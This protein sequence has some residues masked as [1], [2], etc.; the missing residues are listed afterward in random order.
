MLSLLG[1]HST[2]QHGR[3][4]R[5]QP[6]KAAKQVRADQSATTHARKQ[7]RLEPA[8]R[9]GIRTARCVLETN[10]EI[11]MCPAYKRIY[12]HSRSSLADVM[13]PVHCSF[14][15]SFLFRLCLRRPFVFV[16]HGARGT[17]KSP[18]CIKNH[19]PLP[20]SLNRILFNSSLRASVAGAGSR[21]WSEAPC[22]YCSN[23]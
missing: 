7:N 4:Q 12:N 11:A 6:A 21:K 14:S 23:C 1:K 20:A 9:R 10:E 3:A 2:A 19:R 5:S 17:C 22:M 16:D 15:P 18:V 13:L 8:C